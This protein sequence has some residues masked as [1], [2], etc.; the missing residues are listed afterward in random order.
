[1]VVGAW[2]AMSKKWIIGPILFYHIINAIRYSEQILGSFIDSLPDDDLILRYFQQDRALARPAQ[3]S[4]NH[5]QTYY[6]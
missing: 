6:N 3:E 4:I 5:L 1:M 2:V